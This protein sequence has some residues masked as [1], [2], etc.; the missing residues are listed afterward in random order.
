MPS[1]A[2]LWTGLH[3][4]VR[5]LVRRDRVE[6]ELTDEIDGYVDLLT[7]EKIAQG[8]SRDDARRVARLE[9]GRPEHLKDHVRDV[10]VGAWLDALRQDVRFGVRTLIR[11]PGFTLVAVLTLALGI[12]ANSAIFALADAALLRPLPFPE[13]DRLVMIHEHTPTVDRGIVGL[14]EVV[15]WA[16]RNRTFESMTPI[17]ANRRVIADA[18]G[19][20]EMID[21]QSVSTRFFDV[22]RVAPILGR[23]FLPSD[24]RPDADLV[25]LSERIW[26]DRFGGD[27]G[28]IGRQI[29]IDRNPYTVV[30]V[31]PAGFQVLGPS[32]AWMLVTTSFMRSR[33]AVGHYVRAAGRLA[34]GATL[35][36]A[37]ADLTTVADAFAKER[38]DL[39]KDHG[40]VLEPLHD[41]LISTDLRLTAKLLLG[42]IAFVLLT[43]C[44][45]IANLVLART[46]GRARELAV[47]SALGAGGRRLARLLLTESLVLSAIAAALGAALGAAILATA[48]SLLPPGVLPVDV[49][50]AFDGRVLTFCAA[51]AFGFAIA[52]GALPAWQ[53]A[54]RP[55]LE[56]MTGGGRTSTGGGSTFRSV[57]AMSQVAAAVVM[58][59]GAGLLLRSLVALGSVDPGHR[60]SDV[61]TMAINL[62]F[63]RP[64]A[65]PGTPYATVDAQRQFYDA[66]EREVATVPGV[67]RV[68]WGSA[69][70]LDGWW[71]GYTFQRDGDPPRPESQRDLSHYKH[72]DSAYFETLGIPIVSGRAFTSL[73]TEHSPPVCIVN[74]ALVRRYLG[75]QT[76]LGARLVVRGWTTGRGPLPVREIVGVVGQVR[77]FPDQADTQP[78]IYVPLRQDPTTRLSLVVLPSGGSASALTPAVLAAI[79]RVDKGLPVT[80]VRTIAAIGYEANAAARF[81]AVLIGAFALLVL[82]LAVVGVFGVLAYSVQ[83]RVREFGVRIALGATTSNVLLMVFGGTIRITVAGLVIGLAA[84]A[85]LGRSMSALLFGVRPVDPLTFVGVAAL[86]AVTAALATAVPA[87]R[88]ATVDPIVALRQD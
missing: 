41:G 10:R 83:Q 88:A 71:I 27:P 48:P 2:S 26:R 72:V 51:A 35:A 33:T 8:L 67:R 64:D 44:A 9:L 81:R 17:W 18:D 3:H 29:R 39:N 46:S 56:A 20:G 68:T 47:R 85:I 87:F 78:Q 4:F 69:L 65:P 28:V 70:P 14:Y 79:A 19:T 50:L 52:L 57:L 22:F 21:M 43:C 45:N 36:N 53:A 66:V 12:G 16:A 84:A 86:L 34:P 62:P 74:E 25:V 75:G 1:F 58:L 49:R 61:L 40:V 31:V 38:P 11:R 24:D 7:E 63:V 15:E 82:T 60:A 13:A 6:R 80:K 73:D 76:P 37:Q 5:N 32:N 77:E 55:P 59:C 42:V 23:T 54:R 30:G